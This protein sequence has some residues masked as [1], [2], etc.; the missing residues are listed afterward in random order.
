MSLLLLLLL[1]SFGAMT[2]TAACPAYRTVWV[3]G[4]RWAGMRDDQIF[5]AEHAR[6]TDTSRKGSR[7]LAV[8]AVSPISP[9]VSRYAPGS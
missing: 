5:K 3:C 2:V 6:A 1:D 7:V 8:S 9:S 4:W